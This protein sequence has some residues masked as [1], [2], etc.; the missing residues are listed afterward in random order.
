LFAR[1]AETLT[2]HFSGNQNTILFSSWQLSL[3]E[4]AL[5]TLYILALTL[6]KLAFFMMEQDIQEAASMDGWTDFAFTRLLSFTHSS[7]LYIFDCLCRLP[8]ILFSSHLTKVA[9]YLYRLTLTS[10][11]QIL[12]DLCFV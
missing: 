6:Q 10:K 9:Y 2:R 7:F 8:C 12:H 3:T 5:S 11:D 1:A 4:I